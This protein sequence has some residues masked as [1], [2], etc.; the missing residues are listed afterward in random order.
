MTGE[1]YSDAELERLAHRAIEA[2]RRGAGFPGAQGVNLEER[3]NAEYVL[4]MAR[5]LSLPEI[6]VTMRAGRARES[7]LALIRN[8]DQSG[9]AA[10]LRE[11]RLI[12]EEA[13]LSREA[14]IAAESFQ[15]PAEAFLFYRQGAW[16]E[17]VASLL[18]AIEL[19]DTMREEFD[20]AVEVRRIHLARNIIRVKTRSGDCAGAAGKIGP[21]LEYTLGNVTKWPLGKVPMTR[22]PEVMESA[23]RLSLVD[24]ILGEIALLLPWGRV[25]TP[26]TRAVGGLALEATLD[27]RR[28]ECG[29]VSKWLAA[30]RA[31]LH[32]NLA[33][34][35]TSAASFFAEG[36]WH[37]GQAWKDLSAGL[38]LHCETGASRKEPNV[39]VAMGG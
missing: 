33:G 26:E 23:E 10:L 30:R 7:G 3:F 29:Q 39:S 24:Q 31:A 4:R 5:T 12:L 37:L 20:Y 38:R 11:A 2:H 35:L 8:G 36:P 27:T 15:H 17:A 25:I 6:A 14:L 32:G 18:T 16:D 22:D 28:A 34:F 13:G 19:C 1:P 9:G 21:L